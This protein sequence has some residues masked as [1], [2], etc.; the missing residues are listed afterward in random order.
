MDFR[1]GGSKQRL[2]DSDHLSEIASLE[3][4]DRGAAEVNRD[5]LGAL[6]VLGLARPHDHLGT[7][8]RGQPAIVCEQRIGIAKQISPVLVVNVERAPSD[9]RD[10]LARRSRLLSLLAAFAHCAPSSNPCDRTYKNGREIAGMR[11]TVHGMLKEIAGV[12]ARIEHGEALT[13]AQWA[14]I[15]ERLDNDAAR[16]AGIE[17][18]L[19]SVENKVAAIEPKVARKV[20]PPYH[21]PIG[22]AKICIDVR[23][24]KSASK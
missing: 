11:Q 14:E 13:E 24:M 18:R 16:L 1:I 4:P 8:L 6:G 3:A 2:H 22:S 9:V 23:P 17:S 10:A 5:P 20:C 7:H 21:K 12:I 19:D 15:T